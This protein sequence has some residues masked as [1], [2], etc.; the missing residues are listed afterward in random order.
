MVEISWILCHEVETDNLAQLSPATAPGRKNIL[1][2]HGDLRGFH[3]DFM[4]FTRYVLV[5]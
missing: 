4:G 2:A 5:I 1:N 3:E